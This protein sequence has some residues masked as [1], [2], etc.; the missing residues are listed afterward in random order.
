[1]VNVGLKSS[2]EWQLYFRVALLHLEINQVLTCLTSPL[3]GTQSL[4][5]VRRYDNVR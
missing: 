1:M 4:A 5:F 2:E 3:S